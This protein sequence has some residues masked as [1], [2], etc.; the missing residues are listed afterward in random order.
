LADTGQQ[1]YLTGFLART[2]ADA[3][4]CFRPRGEGKKRELG[5][6]GV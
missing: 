1:A 4:G 6:G 2:R 3:R 5:F